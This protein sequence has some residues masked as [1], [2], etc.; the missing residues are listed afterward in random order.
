MK[1][2]EDVIDIK[3]IK[4]PKFLLGMDYEGLRLLSDEIRKEIIRATDLYGGH[5]SSNLGVVELTIALF[6][7]FAF[8]NDKLIFD[9]GH[10]CYT[11]KILTGRP[12]ENLNRK[13]SVSGFQSREESPY[14]PFD[15]GHAGTSL[16]AAL[17]FAIQ[18]DLDKEKRE[19]VAFIGDASLTNGMAFEALNDIGSKGHKVIVIYNDNGMAI[20]KAIGGLSHGVMRSISTAGSYNRMKRKF[21]A[22]C[23]KTRFGRFVYRT[24][25]KM[26]T[27][28][29]KL[30]VREN[31]FESLGFAY[32]GP[33]DGHDFK[34]LEKALER[35][36][37]ATKPVIVHVR[38]IKGKGLKEAEED[39]LGKWHGVSSVSDGN[40]EAAKAVSWTTY[41]A[42]A[43]E[44]ELES[45][46]DAVLVCPAMAY[47]SELID[48]FRLF[49]DR[50][51]DVGIAEEHAVT[52]A[53][54]LALTG[55]KPILSIYSSFLQRSYDQLL[56]DAARL[57]A[58]L[59]ILVDRA[60]FIGYNGE[61]H[62]GIYDEAFLKTIPNFSV[63]MP[64]T[65][66]EFDFLLKEVKAVKGPKAIRY[67]VEPLSREEE[68]AEKLVFGEWRFASPEID[69]TLP[70]V[71][72]VGPK[73]REFRL[74]AE[75]N[76]IKANYVNPLI[77]FPIPER[78]V[79]RILES[80]RVFV[81]DPY[82]TTKGFSES[83]GAILSEKGYK[84]T[85]KA[86]AI[87]SSFVPHMSCAEQERLTR[88]SLDEALEALSLFLK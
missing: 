81:F 3:S 43:I 24:L 10:Q 69:N 51:F 52:F 54:A 48:C 45:D 71:I 59:T 8:P 66:R 12:L 32:V 60:G 77:L 16:S 4:D 53:S 79:E 86:L 22:S 5:L 14:D 83:L 30:V 15:A 6:R 67:P 13:G 80:P 7:K 40:T 68:S 56:H 17:A 36:K 49:P 50:S 46:K 55:K 29:R 34:A 75:K 47:G 85:Y 63:Y 78:S 35:A 57:S 20:G 61:T 76:G 1:K 74:L 38:T 2:N 58:D 42:K 11:A 84:G 19:V 41:V 37:N 72:H 33:V 31:V 73:G 87:P 39:T 82:G 28:I 27:A 70:I 88:V 44:K 26:K 21:R 65:D 23:E 25:W 64:S 9:V 62:Q 18:R